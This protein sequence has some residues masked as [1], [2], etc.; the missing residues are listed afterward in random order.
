MVYYAAMR[1][2][3]DPRYAVAEDY[4]PGIPNVVVNLYSTAVDSETREYI[5]GPKINSALTDS[6]E[7]PTNPNGT[8]VQE[9]PIISPE[10]YLTAGMPLQTGGFLTQAAVP[11][12]TPPIPASF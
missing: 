2:E 9:V 5:K 3:L 12:L 7:H 6:W 4:E 1:N 8:P 10:A 11:F